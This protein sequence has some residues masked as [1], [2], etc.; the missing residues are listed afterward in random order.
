MPQNNNIFT[1]KEAKDVPYESL[2]TELGNKTI[3]VRSNILGN[4]FDNIGVEGQQRGYQ[5]NG[6]TGF[7]P[8]TRQNQGGRTSLIAKDKEELQSVR[9]QLKQATKSGGEVH[10][11]NLNGK[12]CLTDAAK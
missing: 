6:S 9:S 2:Q 12:V 3:G 5:N 10:G 7:E 4:S 8:F 1:K 11:F